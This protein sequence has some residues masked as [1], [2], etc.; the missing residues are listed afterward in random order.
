MRWNEWHTITLLKASKH[1]STEQI[2]DHDKHRKETIGETK[3]QIRV[4]LCTGL[5]GRDLSHKTFSTALVHPRSLGSAAVLDL[6][7]IVWW[8]SS[9][10]IWRSI[11]DASRHRRRYGAQGIGSELGRTSPRA[12]PLALE[13]HAQADRVHRPLLRRDQET[14]LVGPR[15]LELRP[16]LPR[17]H[18]YG[19]LTREA[20]VMLEERAD[21]VTRCDQRKDVCSLC[22]GANNV[23]PYCCVVTH[24]DDLRDC[25]CQQYCGWC[26]QRRRD[27]VGFPDQCIVSSTSIVRAWRVSYRLCRAAGTRPSCWTA[28]RRVGCGY[29]SIDGGPGTLDW[30]APYARPWSGVLLPLGFMTAVGTWWAAMSK[31][32]RVPRGRSCPEK[33]VGHTRRARD[34]WWRGARWCYD[35]YPWRRAARLRRVFRVRAEATSCSTSRRSFSVHSVFCWQS[36]RSV[37]V[38][39]SGISFSSSSLGFLKEWSSDRMNFREWRVEK[40]WAMSSVSRCTFRSSVKTPASQHTLLQTRDTMSVR[41][42]TA[43]DSRERGRSRAVS[44]VLCE[45]HLRVVSMYACSKKDGSVLFAKRKHC[46]TV[47]SNLTRTREQNHSFVSDDPYVLRLFV[48]DSADLSSSAPSSAAADSSSVGSATAVIAIAS[49]T[50]TCFTTVTIVSSIDCPRSQHADD[51]GRRSST[52]RSMKSMSRPTPCRHSVRLEDL[53]TRRVRTRGHGSRRRAVCVRRHSRLISFSSR[54]WRCAPA[55]TLN[56]SLS[57]KHL[58][59]KTLEDHH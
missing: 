19:A 1:S 24:R 33:W 3:G 8:E 50:A 59:W 2:R 37:R 16:F 6:A 22:I 42:R 34:V 53:P 44:G 49:G 41:S 39:A 26:W 45:N 10:L 48:Q 43:A 11:C 51:S 55:S 23:G 17:L 40:W 18:L 52:L 5:L 35:A 58:G 32:W 15:A 20:A 36:S 13:S 56:K 47:Q 7:D 25:A 31:D 30:R 29:T 46:L 21:N 28:H 4:R 38:V 57:D 12:C 9:F 27:G 54:A 14:R